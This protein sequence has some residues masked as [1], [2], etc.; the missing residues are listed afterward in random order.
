MYGPFTDVDISENSYGFNK[1]SKNLGVAK[2]KQIH[3]IL[4]C[5]KYSQRL[6]FRCT[7]EKN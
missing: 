4:V 2:N 7:F 3:S 5:I 1:A 6:F